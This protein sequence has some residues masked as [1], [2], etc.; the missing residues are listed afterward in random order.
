MK[1]QRK[2]GSGVRRLYTVF[3]WCFQFPSALAKIDYQELIFL[4]AKNGYTEIIDLLLKHNVH[5]IDIRNTYDKPPLMIA[6]KEGHQDIVKLL[7][8]N[9]A[10]VNTTDICGR[11]ALM[12]SAFYGNVSGAKFLIEHGANEIWTCV[13][14][15]TG[16]ICAA[17]RG[18]VDFVRWLLDER[19]VDVNQRDRGG[20]IA[21]C[22]AAAHRHDDVVLVLLNHGANPAH[23]NYYD[24]SPMSHTLSSSSKHQSTVDLLL[25]PPA[26]SKETHWSYPKAFRQQ[27]RII[28]LMWMHDQYDDDELNGFDWN[29]LP[30]EVINRII[31]HLAEEQKII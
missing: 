9:G 4:A 23:K 22:Y 16:L 24:K 20:M 11:N 7:I 17:T 1:K 2:I 12:L 30:W 26:W 28:L 3:M 21:L 5:V 14:G 29:M 10:N 15:D 8:D 27:V 18:H 6:S 13:G 25:N 31:G 19:N